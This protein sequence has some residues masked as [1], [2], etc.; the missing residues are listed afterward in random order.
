MA[1]VK[2]SVWLI[3][4]KAVKLYFANIISFLK[5]MTFPVLGQFFGLLIVFGALFLY[6]DNLPKFL[7]KNS[8]FDNF[9]MIFI[10]LLIVILPGFLLFAK[11]FWDYLVAYGAV[12]SML[13]GLMKSGKVYDFP[14]HTEVITRKSGKYIL[15]WSLIGLLSII[16]FFPLF[17]VVGFIMFIYFILVFQVF[18]YEPTKSIFG[19]FKKSVEIIKGN[20]ARTLGL[21]TLVA[22]LTYFLI[23]EGILFLLE[24]TN[25]LKFISAPFA[26][27]ME[28]LPL[29]EINAWFASI[30]VPFH[31]V[32][33]GLSQKVISL[34]L[35]C[36]I[37]SYLLP[38]RVI[39]WALWYKNLCVPEA[40]ID[41]NLLD[42]AEG[43]K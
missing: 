9:S 43:K 20:F 30:H 42:R 13:D 33:N 37:F 6:A 41:K 25:V 38:L 27:W 7:V 34:V 32:P 28:Q 11:A 16:A 36:I 2:D 15:L 4:G 5:Y 40:Q 31:L 10:I 21:C 12:N 24:K 8:V 22:I 18:V 14:A 39:C 19:C 26:G 29:N 35:S 3:F 1:K 23:P 17:W